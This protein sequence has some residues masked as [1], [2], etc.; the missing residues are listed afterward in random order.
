MAE[1]EEKSVCLINCGILEKEINKLMEDG[2]IKVKAYFL[3]PTLHM[4]FDE[5][6]VNLEKQ[7]EECS[8]NCHNGI[9]VVY[10]DSCHPEIKDIV[11]NYGA[12]KVQGC[13]NCIEMLLGKETREKIDPEKAFWYL[14]PGWCE[15]W[16]KFLKD[17]LGWDEKEAKEQLKNIK[18]VIF[19]DTLGNYE[20]YKKDIEKFRE[21][22]GIQQ[23][24]KVEVGLEKLKNTLLNAINQALETKK[25]R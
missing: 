15:N 22:S 7:L 6:K 17:S 20:E 23:V 11:R 10:G 21:Y 14:S 5:L 18:K 13:L 3:P 25:E 19:V 9:V 4:D 1:N 16:E 2:A 12:V 8:K 24:E